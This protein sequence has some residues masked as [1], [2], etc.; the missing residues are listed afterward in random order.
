[1]QGN[2]EIIKNDELVMKKPVGMID[3]AEPAQMLLDQMKLVKSSP[4]HIPQAESMCDISQRLCD[5]AR[6]QAMQAGL[7]IEMTKMKR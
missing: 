1:M 5:M 3:L 6:T 4:T 7:I 2:T